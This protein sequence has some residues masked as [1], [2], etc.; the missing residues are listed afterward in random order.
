MH[1]SNI[2]LYA[3][4]LGPVTNQPASGD[5]APASPLA[6]TTTKPT[7]LIGTSNATVISSTLV[8]GVAGLYEIEVTVPP[9]LTVNT[10][11]ISVTIGGKTSKISSLP[12]K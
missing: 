5:P 3:N 9:G 7:V 8:P 11:Q 12:V 2:Y 10:Y 6:A 1:G 4:G